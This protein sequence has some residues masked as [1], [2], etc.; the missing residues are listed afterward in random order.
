MKP[1]AAQHSSVPL[2]SGKGESCAGAAVL[3]AGHGTRAKG[4]VTQ[5]AARGQ[6]EKQSLPPSLSG[7][8]SHLV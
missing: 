6:R 7:S 5:E 1:L 4:T 3:S 2:V 8:I